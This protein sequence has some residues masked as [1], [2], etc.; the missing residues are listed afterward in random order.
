MSRSAT[1][2]PRVVSI[3]AGGAGMFCGSCMRD[4]TLAATLQRLGVPVTLMPTFTPIRTDE[5]DVSGER[6][7]LGGI[8]VYL[9]QKWPWLGR[10]PRSVRRALD[11]PRLLRAVAE[12]ALQTRRED[13][14]A[15]AISLLH[16]LR[17]RQR[18]ATR[19][20]IDALVADPRPEIVNVSNLLIAGFVPDLK[21]RM[22]VPVV[23]T[24]Q[25]DDIFL[26]TLT[27]ADRR[28]ALAEMR[29]I[30][31]DIDAFVVFSR[32]YGERMAALFDIAPELVHTVPLGLASPESCWGDDREQLAR[33]EADRPPTVGYLARL[34]P[35]K[36]FH[37]LVDAFLL[38]RQRSQTTHAR[39]LFGG[40]LGSLDREFF[41]RQM[42]KIE[43][44]GALDAV[45]RMDLPDRASKVRM[46]QQVDV[47]SVPTVYREPK[48]LYV[49]EALAAGVPVAQPAHGSFP[50]LLASTGGGVLVPPEQPTALADELHG[51][52]LDPERRRRLGDQGRRGVAERH[53]AETMARAT[54]DLWRR[55]A[56]RLG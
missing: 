8:N 28:K 15:V 36:G 47:F 23:A 43:A 12:R 21:Q 40:W 6:I 31:R 51:L 18:S 50:E 44:A 54:L 27:A 19:D 4:N 35:E 5:E 46:L 17:G 9:E 53:S 3:T 22:D 2:G 45:T 42:A 11:H 14:G 41:D 52:L 33:S 24:L 29:R 32:D 39:L 34:C 7:G 25:G 13:D 56:D 48:G 55:L 49:L 10:L 26:D 1:E 37:H 20:L 16:G 38:L 30:V